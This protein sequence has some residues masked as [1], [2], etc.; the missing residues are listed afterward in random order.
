MITV[1]FQ[2]LLAIAAVILVYITVIHRML[3]SR[4]MS[5]KLYKNFGLA[6]LSIAVCVSCVAAADIGLMYINTSIMIRTESLPLEEIN[7]QLHILMDYMNQQT[8]LVIACIVF[9]V[10]LLLLVKSINKD[11][12]KDFKKDK[13]RWSSVN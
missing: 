11:I 8:G 12:E 3:I 4:Q 5:D 2:T 1:V 10:L 13:Y 9:Y 7:K 6:L